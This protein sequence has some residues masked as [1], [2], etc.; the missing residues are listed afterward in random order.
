MLM[1]NL[2]YSYSTTNQVSGNLI[3]ENYSTGLSPEVQFGYLMRSWCLMTFT[4]EYTSNTYTSVSAASTTQT[5]DYNSS[6]AIGL[7]L[8]F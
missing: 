7:R 8:V 4:V 2:P 5:V 6:T 1:V 3:T